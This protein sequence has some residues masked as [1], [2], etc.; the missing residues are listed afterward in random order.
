MDNRLTA[1]QW[2]SRDGEALDRGRPS[3]LQAEEA[4]RTLI[5]WAGDD[6]TREGL[7]DTPERVARAYE[8]WFAG[9][10]EVPSQLLER[11]FEE[12]AGY[13]EIV[14]LRDIH[15]VAGVSTM[16]H[17]S[18]GVPTLPTYPTAAWSV[19]RNSRVWSKCSPSGC[20][21]RRE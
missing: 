7:L 2:T 12:I 20:K 18:S 4:V 10:N 17:P 16:W 11:C 5:S 9:Y 1:Q 6:P 19:F 14:L 21:F 8:E 13:N 3:R 15:F